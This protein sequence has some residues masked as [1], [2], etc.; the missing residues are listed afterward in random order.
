MRPEQRESGVDTFLRRLGSVANVA[1]AGINTYSG[2]K[3]LQSKSQAKDDA[4]KGIYADKDQDPTKLV[5]ATEGE[6]GAI[7]RKVRRGEE[8]KDEWFKNY[9]AQEK[10]KSADEIANT[11]A[12]TKYKLSQAGKNWAEVAKD[13]NPETKKFAQNEYQSAGFA[14]RA[15]QAQNA[16]NELT[17]TG[18]NPSG[19]WESIGASKLNPDFTTPENAKLYTQAKSDFV[20]AVLRKESGAAIGDA[21]RAAE[22]RKYF[23]QAGDTDKVKEQKASSRAAALATLESEAGGALG[24]VQNQLSENN[25]LKKLVAGDEKYQDMSGGKKSM[26]GARGTPAPPKTVKQNG[27]TYTLNEKTGQYE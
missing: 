17:K 24:R 16:F 11:Q 8:V 4:N 3:D 5:P 13:K 6:S 1:N 18:Y 26:I 10:S 19:F 22:E 20:S 7:Q 2:Y 25:S 23:P 14:T 12:D 9:V 21:E 27:I 15:N